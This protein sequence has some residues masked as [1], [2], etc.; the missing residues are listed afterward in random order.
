MQEGLEDIQTDLVTPE[1]VAEE[2]TAIGLIGGSLL[3]VHRMLELTPFKV[4]LTAAACL[5]PN[6]DSLLILVPGLVASLVG[7]KSPSDTYTASGCASTV[8]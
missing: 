7:Y 1:H 6:P 8:V 5:K 2:L 4:I 3:A